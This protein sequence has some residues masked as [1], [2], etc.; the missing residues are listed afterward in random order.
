MKFVGDSLFY[1]K[2]TKD[3]VRYDIRNKSSHLI[4][5]TKDA[6][7]ALYVTRNEIREFDR[8]EEEKIGGGMI[9]SDEIDE[10]AKTG[11]K[12]TLTCLDESENLYI[13]KSNNTGKKIDQL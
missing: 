1:V 7:I 8:G 5:T 10:E 9:Q 2:N 13:Y 4:G 11:S 12:F 6:I 3:L